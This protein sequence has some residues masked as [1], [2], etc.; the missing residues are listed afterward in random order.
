[1]VTRVSTPGNYSAVLSNLLA[2]QQRQM[3]A[4]VKV[5]TQKNGSDLKDY[6][7]D[8]EMLTAMRS[9]K[10][11]IEVYQDQN[12]FISE[13]LATQD[14]ALNAI[15][16]SAQGV[17]QAIADALAS[18]RV[19]TLMEDLQAHFRTAIEGM[20]ARYGGKYVFAGGQ[21]DTRPVTA[22]ALADLT[23]GPPIASWFQNDQFVV[24]AK[25][26]EATS[27]QL[28]ILANN[29]GTGMLTALQTIQTF[30]E[31]GSGPFTGQMTAAQRTF[32][33]GQL[34]TWDGV[35]ENLT[36]ITARNGLLQKRVESVRDDLQTRHNQLSGMIGDITDADMA[37][38]VAQLEQAQLAVQS[39]AHVFTTLQESSLLNVL[40]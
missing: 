2:A 10:T 16:N 23:S 21:V 27:V 32:L 25:V 17:R 24:E 26:D 37:E 14:T 11:R 15:A 31:G 6:A 13:R 33:E 7:R 39:A 18:G 8:A 30:H 4:G 20:N 1:M 40:R 38:A 36:N 28:G 35:R 29:L 5:A 9:L 3:A 12:T 22:T 19:D 34:S